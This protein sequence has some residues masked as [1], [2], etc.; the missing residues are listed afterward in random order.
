MAA[1]GASAGPLDG[2]PEPL[3]VQ[4]ADLDLLRSNRV[5]ERAPGG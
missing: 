4:L 2:S 5:S 1:G 3:L